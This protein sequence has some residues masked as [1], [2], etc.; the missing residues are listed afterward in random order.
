MLTT[1]DFQTIEYKSNAFKGI[2]FKQAKLFGKHYVVGKFIV[3]GPYTKP[4]AD[5]HYQRLI[6]MFKHVSD[7]T[8]YEI[9]E[10]YN[11]VQVWK[12]NRL[13][14]TGPSFNSALE[15]INNH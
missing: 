11:R 10:F 1:Q 13:E 7:D 4:E 3:M 8:F 2:C 15:F 9:Y 14:F 12:F 5:E 6:P